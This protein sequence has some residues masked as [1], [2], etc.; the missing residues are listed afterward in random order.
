MT[1]NV[2]EIL[3]KIIESGERSL[4]MQGEFLKAVYELKSHLAEGNRDHEEMQRN[5]HEI[6]EHA[7][8]MH[9]KMKSASNEMII[10]LLQET[11]KEIVEF[12]ITA[13]SFENKIDTMIKSLESLN[14]TDIIKNTANKVN[15]LTSG[16]QKLRWILGSITAI[17]TLI[18]S[19]AVLVN[20][21]YLDSFKDQNIKAV[22]EIKI[23]LRNMKE[24]QL[25]KDKK[26]VK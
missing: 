10:K 18:G 8:E 25:K 9:D 15:E 22:Q 16:D 21:F 1:I 19:S 20:K 6:L 23:E 5:I 11:S 24:E 7:S 26:W 13:S 12:K 2:H 3:N 4:D 14:T 17:C